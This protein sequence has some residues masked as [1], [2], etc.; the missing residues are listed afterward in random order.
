MW[1]K[2]LFFVAG[3]IFFSFVHGKAAIKCINS[4]GEAII[5]NNDIPSAKVEAIARA[6]WNAIEQVAGVMIKAQSVVQNMALIDEMVSK[7]I[8]G[9]V[10]RYNVKRSWQEGDIYKVV[11]N[12]CVETSKVNNALELLSLN[13]SIAVFVIA[14]KPSLGTFGTEY[15][16]T[17]I[18]SEAIIGKLTE[19]EIRVID[20][21]SIYPQEAWF[22]EQAMKSGDFMNLRSF[23]YQSLSNILLIGKVDY[24]ISIQKGEDIGYGISMPF[25][26]VTARLI[27]RLVAKKSSSEKII[28]LAAG[29]EE[30]KGIAFNVEDAVALSMKDL[31]ERF[32]PIIYDKLSKYIQGITKKVRIKVLDVKDLSKTFKIKDLIQNIAWV[33]EVEVKGF[34]EFIVS[35]PENT[36]YLA[37]S[38]SQKG[39]K[40]VE[41]GSDLIILKLEG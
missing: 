25:N 40:I 11:A 26:S 16:E 17:N 1:I 39:F 38:L 9:L 10:T 27:Y 28:I 21:A 33:T 2:V 29:V 30:G 20:I 5:I 13:N 8:K 7:Q 14:K 18:L 22:I 31:A 3:L 34:G 35:Y 41:F 19:N 4:E 6:K 37:N 32:S 36:I 15:E 24:T 23:M 12:V